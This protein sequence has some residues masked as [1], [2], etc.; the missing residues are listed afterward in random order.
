MKKYLFLVA[1]TVVGLASCNSNDDIGIAAPGGITIT[2]D[3]DCCSAEEALAVYNFLQTLQP[4]SGLSLTVD[5]EY[6]LQVYTPTGTLHTGYNDLYF[7]ATKKFTGNYIKFLEITNLAPVMQMGMG[8]KHST[9]TSA[10]AGVADSRLTAVKHG[11]VSFL[12]PSGDMGSWTLSFDVE[13]LRRKASLQLASV[14][15]DVLPEGQ[16]W[17]KSFKVGDDTFYLSLA[18]PSGWQTGSNTLTAYISKKS[19]DGVSPYLPATEVFT[20]DI[21]PR[22]PDMGNHTSPGN[23][24]LLPK[25]DG[26]YQGTVN[27]TMTGLWRIHLTVMDAEGNIV[28]GGDDL[29]GGYSSLFWDVTL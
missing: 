18:D 14:S 19:S 25:A 1:A 13:V 8:M 16:A 20:V 27:L 17:L 10:Q 7:V 3:A 11:W 15:V 6:D 2:D 28:A 26:S 23:T 5:D 9:P 12:M 24:P 21:D 22:M 29:D 4:V